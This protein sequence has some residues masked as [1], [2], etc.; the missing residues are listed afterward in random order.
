MIKGSRSETTQYQMFALQNEVHD[1]RDNSSGS[2]ESPFQ[3]VYKGNYTADTF[4][5][6]F[7]G[8][9]PFHGAPLTGQS[10]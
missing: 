4:Q 6:T 7:S 5:E 8:A 1:L 3:R 10:K 9:Q 2:A